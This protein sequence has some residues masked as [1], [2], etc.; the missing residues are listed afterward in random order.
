MG[1]DY[2]KSEAADCV[3]DRKKLNRG[4][5]LDMSFKHST[6]DYVLIEIVK[7]S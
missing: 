4:A 6:A 3:M 1:K 5:Y 2:G 7:W